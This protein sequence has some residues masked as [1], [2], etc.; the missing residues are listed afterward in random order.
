MTSDDLWRAAL[1]DF[2]NLL[3]GL[4][5]VLDL[6]DP[7]LPLDARNR[8]R[9]ES[10]LEDGKSLIVMARA[11]ALGRHPD[12]DMASW[13]EW[14]AGLEAKLGPMS[15]MFRCPIV[16]AALGA[17]T[18]SWPIPHLQDWAAAF[19][20]QILPWVAPG[21][22]RLEARVSPETWILTWVGDAP[23]PAAL[24][25]ELPSDAPKNLSSFWLR[26]TSER[27]G[28]SIQETPEGIVVQMARQTAPVAATPSEA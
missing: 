4:Q 17:E 8:M 12:A 16:L 21:P 24:R 14:K 27:L 2:N 20:R 23:L 13:D 11:L 19:T 6:S 15:A 5:G 10:T 26:A 9:L 22:L 25:S 18:A 7:G 1:H 28:L 3:A